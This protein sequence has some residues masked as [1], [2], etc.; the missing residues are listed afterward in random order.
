VF[1]TKSAFNDQDSTKVYAKGYKK[2]IRFLNAFLESLNKSCI[3][4]NTIVKIGKCALIGVGLKS[5]DLFIMAL[6]NVY[7]PLIRLQNY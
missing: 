1:Q 2:W 3:V 4:M 6:K 7:K 5:Y